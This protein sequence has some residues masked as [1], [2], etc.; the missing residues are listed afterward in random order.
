MTGSLSSYDPRLWQGR[1]TLPQQLPV[2][3]GRIS[4]Q[5]HKPD[6]QTSDGKRSTLA[7]ASGLCGHVV[8]R[9]PDRDTLPQQCPHS[10]VVKEPLEFTLQRV[11]ERTLKRELQ[12]LRST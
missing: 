2:K 4:R 7:C 5:S 10:E 11:F 8:S 1:E 9:S 6:A 3:F 12:R